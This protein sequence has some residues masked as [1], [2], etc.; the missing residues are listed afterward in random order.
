MVI[1]LTH[2]WSRRTSL[3]PSAT[4]LSGFFGLKRLHFFPS[5]RHG[6]DLIRF[7]YDF[8][9][10]DATVAAIAVCEKVK[11]RVLYGCEEECVLMWNEESAPP[12]VD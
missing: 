1:D 10:R 5:L 4:S 12:R 7:G 3:V 6:L 11:H 8:D 9:C 2:S